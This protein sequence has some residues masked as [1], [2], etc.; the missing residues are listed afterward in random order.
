MSGQNGQIITF[1]PP[2]NTSFDE[3]VTFKVSL[4]EYPMTSAIQLLIKV[5]MIGELLL[6][7]MHPQ[8]KL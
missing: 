6:L 5:L 8:I 2:Q 4:I 7:M 3:T 1:S